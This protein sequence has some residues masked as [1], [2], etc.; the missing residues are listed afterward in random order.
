MEIA[1]WMPMSLYKRQGIITPY[2]EHI[3]RVWSI[4]K[5]Q[6]F[7][8]YRQTMPELLDQWSFFETIQH[9]LKT[10][11]L[12]G[13]KVLGQNEN[14][15][16][17]YITLGAKNAYLSIVVADSQ[18][19]FYSYSCFRSS[20]V[21]NSILVEHSSVIYASRC[22]SDSSLIFYSSNIQQSNNIRYCANMMGC[23]FCY[24]CSNLV[25]QSYCINNQVVGKEVYLTQMVA[26]RTESFE[27]LQTKILSISWANIGTK[28]TG[29][30]NKMCENI[31]NGLMNY[32]LK[33][34]RNVVL[35]NASEPLEYA[36]DCV[37]VWGLKSAHIYASMGVWYGCERVY[38]SVECSPNCNNVHYSYLMDT[39]SFCLWC[40]WLKNKQFCIFNKQYT[41]EE[42]YVRAEEI[43]RRMEEE[44]TLW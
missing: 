5:A 9:G 26:L 18:N 16:Y 11:T 28:I 40:I 41:K 37:S 44:W 3:T 7:D 20:D 38:C 8:T 15:E 13:T 22:V 12:A 23:S 42:R 21:Y 10:A 4:I 25:N 1:S 2:N 43:F 14:A 30:F 36:L 32:N 35:A 34:A 24:N 17:S 27:D 6:D 19:I 31:E 39:C 33:D 29:S